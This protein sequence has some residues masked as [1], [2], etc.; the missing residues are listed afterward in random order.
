VTEGI[1]NV[2]TIQAL[3]PSPTLSPT[4]TNTPEP[5]ATATSTV[6]PT[7]TATNTPL[8]S[9][10]PL[11]PTPTPNPALVGFSFC[12]Q[13]AGPTDGL[14][15]ARMAEVVA[16]GTPAY[17][18]VVLRFE[19]GDGSAPLGATAACLGPAGVAA[20]DPNQAA[21]YALSVHL[22]GWL[23]DERYAASPITQT[24]SFTGTRTIT[25][26]RIIPAP[27]SDAGATLLFGLSEPLPFRLTIERN[28]T[29]LVLAVAHIRPL[30]PQA[31]NCA[32]SLAAVSRRSQH[33]SSPSSMAIF[34]G[35]RPLRKA[36]A[37]ASHLASLGP[38]TSRTRLK[39]RPRWPLA[40][41]GQWSPFA[42]PPLASTRLMPS[43]LCP[44]PS[45]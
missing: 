26:A 17:E 20:T 39:P 5:T 3:T 6:G 28:P 16:N 35:L 25:S 10:T 27:T 29:R 14:F 44:A 9:A 30:S 21:P 41:M 38:P 22:P 15:S 37:L 42:A 24:L 12:D 32:W 1:T 43:C 18:Q 40:P 33:H 13:H 2:Q 36:P 34:G 31:T 8:P 23:H 11:P 45:G 7:P 4:V 19:L